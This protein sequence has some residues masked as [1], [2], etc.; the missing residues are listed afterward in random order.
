[1]SFSFF[2]TR[3][4]LRIW[5]PD[6]RRMM[7]RLSWDLSTSR[8]P[9]FPGCLQIS[10]VSPLWALDGVTWEV[11]KGASCALLINFIVYFTS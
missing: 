7:F 9:A 2:F 6:G 5:V 11:Q 4:L 10:S 8:V 1:M 3:L